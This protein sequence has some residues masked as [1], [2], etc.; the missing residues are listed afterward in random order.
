MG[1]SLSFVI[2]SFDKNFR[3]FSATSR[4]FFSWVISYAK[5]NASGSL[6]FE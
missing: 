5:N 3:V 4:Y 6:P 1:D 2:K